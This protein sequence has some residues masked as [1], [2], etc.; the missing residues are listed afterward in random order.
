M[1]ELIF[2]PKKIQYGITTPMRIIW[3]LPS[4]EQ[5]VENFALLYFEIPSTNNIPLF[6]NSYYTFTQMLTLFH[7]E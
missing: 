4:L 1:L 7:F 3:V 5:C 2:Q 6:P